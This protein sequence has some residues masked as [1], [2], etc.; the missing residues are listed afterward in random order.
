MLV[1]YMMRV[2][3]KSLDETERGWRGG[4]QAGRSRDIGNVP[5]S[6]ICDEVIGKY[7]RCLSSLILDLVHF[8]EQTIIHRMHFTIKSGEEMLLF[9]CYVYKRERVRAPQIKWGFARSTVIKG[10]QEWQTKV[11][12]CIC[13]YV[14]SAPVRNVSAVI[15][16]KCFHNVNDFWD[17]SRKES[18]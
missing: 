17:A 12:K 10:F 13:V 1:A 15:F 2:N 11:R 5:R 14:P 16:G 9:V 18:L 4:K 8:K 6:Q 3:W 7:W